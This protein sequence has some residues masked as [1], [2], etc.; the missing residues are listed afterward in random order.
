LKTIVIIGRSH[1]LRPAGSLAEHQLFIL[2]YA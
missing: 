2:F 1:R